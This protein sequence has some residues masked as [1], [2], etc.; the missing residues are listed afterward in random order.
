MRGDSMMIHI[1]HLF[2]IVPL[3]ATISVATMA[4][5]IVGKKADRFED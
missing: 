5:L 3:T 1:A 2:W 4:I